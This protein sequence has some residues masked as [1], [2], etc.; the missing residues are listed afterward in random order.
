MSFFSASARQRGYGDF[1]LLRHATPLARRHRRAAPPRPAA[2]VGARPRRR[3]HET[4]A[5]RSRS[6]SDSPGHFFQRRGASCALFARRWRDDFNGEAGRAAARSA[7]ED[8]R[9][10]ERDDVMFDVAPG[11]NSHAGK[12]TGRRISAVSN[13]LAAISRHVASM[14]RRRFLS[15]RRKAFSIA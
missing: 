8:F 2:S 14:P 3:Y 6:R 11:T 10:D 12:S 15:A 7:A 1:H 5:A 9:D 13:T 4:C